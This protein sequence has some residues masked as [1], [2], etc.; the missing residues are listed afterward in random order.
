MKLFAVLIFSV[1]GGIAA[2]SLGPILHKY[3]QLEVYRRLMS[4][5]IGILMLQPFAILLRYNISEKCDDREI[6]RHLISNLLSALF[7]GIGVLIGYINDSVAEID[8]AK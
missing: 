5:A 8:N 3:F 4:Y 2:H 7:F 1:M 6:E